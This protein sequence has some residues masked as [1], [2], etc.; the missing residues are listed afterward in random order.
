MIRL[1]FRTLHIEV[2]MLGLIETVR[3]LVL[4]QAGIPSDMLLLCLEPEAAAI[5]CMSVNNLSLNSKREL[6]GFVDKFAPTKKY[7]VVDAGGKN[8]FQYGLT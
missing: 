2:R 4:L 7:I 5:Y 3:N 6:R 8:F 1:T